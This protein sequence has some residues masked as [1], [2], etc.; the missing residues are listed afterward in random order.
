ME[1]TAMETTNVAMEEKLMEMAMATMKRQ[2]W[3]QQTDRDNYG[4]NGCNGDNGSGTR[5][6]DGGKNK[7][8]MTKGNKTTDIGA[9]IIISSCVTIF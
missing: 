7:M 1:T 8:E 9:L 3:W 6:D 5:D 2:R 4:S